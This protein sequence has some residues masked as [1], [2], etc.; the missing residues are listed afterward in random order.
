MP[1][2]EYECG[3]CGHSFE[4]FQYM[5]DKPLR[6][7]PKCAKLKLIRLIGSGAGIIFKGSG[8][9]ETDYKRKE[10]TRPAAGSDKNSDSGKTEAAPAPVSDASPQ[11]SSAVADG[12][13]VKPA[14]A[15]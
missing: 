15:S 13:S 11:T 7:C 3:N 5:S 4:E 10:Q 9:Y 14:K 8:F 12:K 1:T 2:Y 6:K